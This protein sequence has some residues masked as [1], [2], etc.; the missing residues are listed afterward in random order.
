MTI[1]ENTLLIRI[2]IFNE[3][4]PRAKKKDS[5]IILKK[6]EKRG[7]DH[8]SIPE[9]SMA[10]ISCLYNSFSRNV[11]QESAVTKWWTNF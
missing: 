10:C 5:I 9:L 7:R 11:V 3:K 1:L 2:S 6:Y 8:L 4:I